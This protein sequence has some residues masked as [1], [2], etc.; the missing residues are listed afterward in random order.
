[1][2]WAVSSATK[3]LSESGCSTHTLTGNTK[4]TTYTCTATNAAGTTS[5]SVTVKRD[6]TAP[7]VHA[8]ASPAA[9]SAGWRNRVVTVTFTDNDAVSGIAS[10]T[11]PAVLSTEGANQSASG[12]CTDNAGLTGAP[13]TASG[14]SIDLT[15]PAVTVSV[16]TNGAVYARGSTVLASYACTDALS[17]V[18]SCSAPTANGSALPTGT[19]GTKTF[20][21][22]GTDLAANTTK[23]TIS[24]SVK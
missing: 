21:V 2:Q 8:V 16:P 10:C 20:T 24:Y 15:P 11:A 5:R 4:G 3:I 19:S 18:K 9:N 6:A 17:G 23:T 14:I 22:T 12:T 13:V 1:V 7:V